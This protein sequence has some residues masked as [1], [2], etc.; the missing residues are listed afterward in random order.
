M[1]G[2]GKIESIRLNIVDLK[3]NLHLGP[4]AFVGMNNLRLLQI[5]DIGPFTE[6]KY[7][8][9]PPKE[10]FE[11]LPNELRCISWQ[12]Y[13]WTSFPL[14]CCLKNLVELHFYYS[15]LQ[16]LWDGVLVCNRF[17]YVTH[18]NFVQIKSIIT[19]QL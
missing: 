3:D 17:V 5:E 13:P 15:K 10:G 12:G 8:V 16:K 18:F 6:G 1:Q 19:I 7:M 14:R 4:Q 2:T 11:S 9:W